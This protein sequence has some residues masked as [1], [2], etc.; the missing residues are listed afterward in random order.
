MSLSKVCSSGMAQLSVVYRNMDTTNPNNQLNVYRFSIP[1]LTWTSSASLPL[2]TMDWAS[3]GS[4]GATGTMKAIK[5]RQLHPLTGP[6]K[7]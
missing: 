4:K 3:P 6:E 5:A 2:D 1:A 7:R